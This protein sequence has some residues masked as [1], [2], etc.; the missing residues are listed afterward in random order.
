MMNL[1]LTNYGHRYLRERL[2]QPTAAPG[3]DEDIDD[4][5]RY[6]QLC[7]HCP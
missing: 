4:S 1:M 6:P 2:R 7:N 3:L 5:P